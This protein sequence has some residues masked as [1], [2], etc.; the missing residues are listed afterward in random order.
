MMLLE[1]GP[2]RLGERGAK[3]VGPL[4]GDAA[5]EIRRDG[6]V[7]P[8]VD[9]RHDVEVA[10]G[11]R[12]VDA[13]PVGAEVRVVERA[14]H[15]ARVDEL[16]E[17]HGRA[18][19][20]V[21]ERQLVEEVDGTRGPEAVPV[22]LGPVPVVWHA[23]RR[24]VDER[25][26]ASQ[27]PL[28]VR[29]ARA[30]RLPE[31]GHGPPPARPLRVLVEE[32]ARLRR[33]HVVAVRPTAHADA[34]LLA[35]EDHGEA[36]VVAD[37]VDEVAAR[38]REARGPV[39]LEHGFG[40]DRRRALGLRAVPEVARRPLEVRVAH[41]G[42][43][44]PKR[45]AGRRHRALEVREVPARPRAGVARARAP[46]PRRAAARPRRVDRTA[47]SFRVR[48]HCSTMPSSQP[49]TKTQ[50]ASTCSANASPRYMR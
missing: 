31:L 20:D 28:A 43:R 27:A 22:R 13:A 38:E 12:V 29:A 42:T 14:V 24:H 6:V 32:H 7:E 35:H 33:V 18:P 41:D 45:I 11:A 9:D 44:L 25:G 47:I 30:A 50:C 5:A 2:R 17:R 26:E 1:L 46:R 34:D 37:A 48:R 39:R 49:L 3:D 23:R 10:R 21:D 16:A 40:R 19:R 4:L 15:G 8:R 36:A